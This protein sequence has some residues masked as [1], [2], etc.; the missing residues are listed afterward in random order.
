MWKTDGLKKQSFETTSVQDHPKV[1]EKWGK[2]LTTFIPRRLKQTDCQT[3][4]TKCLTNCQTT[5][6]NSQMGDP[7]KSKL[8]KKNSLKDLLYGSQNNQYFG[9]NFIIF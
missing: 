3:T 5:I 1:E 2:L 7:F 4:N 9:S 6:T 8:L